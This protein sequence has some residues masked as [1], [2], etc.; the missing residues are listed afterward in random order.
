MVA[1]ALP[2]ITGLGIIPTLICGD[3]AHS[4]LAKFALMAQIIKY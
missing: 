1:I 3:K 2:F 4:T